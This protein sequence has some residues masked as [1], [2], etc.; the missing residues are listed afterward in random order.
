MQAAPHEPGNKAQQS[1]ASDF[2][3][4]LVVADRRELAFWPVAKRLRRPASDVGEDIGCE[5]PGLRLG[6]LSGRWANLTVQRVHDSS[7]VPRRPNAGKTGHRQIVTDREAAA[8]LGGRY[9]S[10][11]SLG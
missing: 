9:A 8:I 1:D 7:A 2:S 10:I 11:R 5:L 4:G 3:D 6:K